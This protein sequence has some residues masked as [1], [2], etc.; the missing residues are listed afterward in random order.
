MRTIGV[1]YTD[2]KKADVKPA[3]NKPPVSDVKPQAEK[4]T[5]KK[6]KK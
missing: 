1:V 6:G 3:E 2:T 5:G 4:E